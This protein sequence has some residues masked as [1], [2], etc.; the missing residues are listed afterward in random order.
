MPSLHP[1]GTVLAYIV[2][3]N[4]NFIQQQLQPDTIGAASDDEVVKLTGNQ[5]I[6]VL[7]HLIL[8]Y[9]TFWILKL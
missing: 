4:D 5:T 2:D 1:S 7:K 6:Q 8:Q 3:G 9:D